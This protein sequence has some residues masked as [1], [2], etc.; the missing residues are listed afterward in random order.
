M[1]SLE[2]S[3]DSYAQDCD[4]ALTRGA[5]LLGESEE[6]FTEWRVAW[7]RKQ[8]E[9]FGF[10]PHCIMDYGCGTGSAVPILDKF[11]TPD[12]VYG[13]DISA[14]SLRVAR[15][16]HA[17]EGHHFMRPEDFSPNG[18]VDF[19]HTNGTF[20]HIP[21][22]ERPRAV[23]YIHRALVP[24]GY[25]GLCENNPW[26]PGTRMVMNRIPFDRDAIMLSAS[27][28]SRMLRRQGFEIVRKEFLFIFPHALRALRWIEPYCS[29]MPLGAQYIVLGRKAEGRS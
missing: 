23:Q 13:I 16:S 27:N 25:I 4:D 21:P 15:S 6:Y 20:H 10:N 7:L 14:E 29:W 5:S 26:N 24:G 18:Q 22:R 17:G 11:F 19:V 2:S 28:A 12:S 9:R 1:T 8:A 3:V